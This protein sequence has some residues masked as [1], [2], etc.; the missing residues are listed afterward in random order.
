MKRL[1]IL[2]ATLIAGLSACDSLL[3]KEPLDRVTQ[4]DY[5]K[6][7]SDLELFSNPFYDNLL[8]KTPYDEQNDLLVQMTLSD[9]LYGGDKRTVPNTGGGWSWGNLRRINTLLEYVDQCEDKDAVLEYT[10]L[11][12]FFR[13]AFYFDKVKRFGDVP[14]YDTQLGSADPDLYKARDSRELVM[15][16]MIEDVDFAINSGGLTEEVT[17]Y[18]VNKWAALAL[19]AR[20]CLFEYHGINLEGHDYT[21]YLE[22]AAKAAKTIIDEGPYK[23]YSTKN[24][25]KDYM[26]LFAQENASTEEYIL[27]IRNSYE[28]QVYH[29]ATAYTLLPTQGRPGYT[30]KFINMYLMKNGT[31]FTD[32]TDGWQTLPFTEEVKDRDPRLAQS[33]RT[34]GY[35]RIGAK[36]VQGPDLGV[37]ITGYQ[38]IK[39]VQDT[40][41]SGGQIDRNDRSTCDMPVFRYAE[42]LLNYAEAKAELGTLTQDD[43]TI[44]V[45]EIRNRVEMPALNMAEANKNPD[46]YLSSEEYGYPNVTGANKGVILEIRRERAVELIQ[47]GLR[48]QDLYRWKAGY[49]IDQTI[50]GMYFPGPG[51]YDLSGKGKT[52]LIL[53]T[54]GSTKPKD[55][56]GVSVYELGS[57]IIL[58]EG[59]KG[60]V[61]YH[62]TVENLRTPFNEERDYLYPIPS[63]ERSLNPNLTQNPGWSDGLNF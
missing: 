46:W 26:M 38:P 50:S 20:F 31:A 33:I 25:D 5:F 34:P 2:A 9:I 15:T 51:E 39:F 13:A 32:R 43:L 11:S 56:E 4:F 58:S 1:I 48:L 41:A 27:A 22:E 47:E 17:P 29:N 55:E 63:G 8:D 23:I 59:N 42:V 7:K 18:R 10:A 30:R 40:T 12:R 37:T 28:A 6:T 35:K 54:A 3:D 36:R 60:Y 62:K 53:Y 49:C 61:Y 45:N 44:S 52:D 16:K 14:W 21:Y 24:P 57:D 19:K